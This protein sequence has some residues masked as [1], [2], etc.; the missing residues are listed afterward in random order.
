MQLSDKVLLVFLVIPA[1]LTRVL[2][3]WI[4]RP[5]FVGW[6]NHTYYYYVQT[7]GLLENGAL[8]F[9]D[10]PLLFYIYSIT[11]R[12]LTWL[13]ADNHDAVVNATRF[14]MCLI[15]SLLPLPF[16]AIFKNI[17][18]GQAM[19][20]WVWILVAGSAVYPLSIL[21]MPEFLQKNTLGIVFLTILICLSINLVRKPKLEGILPF[22]G[23]FFLLVLTHYGSTGA[24]VLYCGALILSLI[25]QADKTKAIKMS[26]GLLAG[27]VFALCAF[28]FF[29]IQRFE[30]V[31][32]YIGRMVDSSPIAVIF[33]SQNTMEKIHGILMVTFPPGILLLFYRFYSME[34]IKLPPSVK[35][36]WLSNLIFCYLLVL[37]LYDQLLFGRFSLFLFVPASIV[38]YFTLHYSVSKKWIRNGV[39]GL[40]LFVFILMGFGEIMSLKFHNK[41]KD[42]IFADLSR[43]KT[44]LDLN[45]NDLIIGRNGVE[46]ISNWVLGT[47][48]CVITALNVNDFQKYER[49]FI[50]NP[51]EQGITLQG[52]TNEGAY[53]Y[54]LMLSNVPEPKNGK[55][56]FDSDHLKLIELSSPPV[57]WNFDPDGLWKNFN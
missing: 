27:L 14:W 7:N 44:Q 23:V 39:L 5:E 57:E 24:A 34:K 48:S 37:P 8:P 43:L 32:F 40:Y 54:N 53:R 16:Y 45:E 15:P 28:Y 29:D 49:V 55:P 19:P 3:I 41:N 1:F 11:A 31:G 30:R 33:N 51:K 35:T 20:G 13:G 26:L 6:F 9:R 52:N 2:F 50:L 21:Y 25:V 38:L 18:K 17:F 22:A 36:F 56:V 47:K 42:E 4:D 12:F 46:H 10:M